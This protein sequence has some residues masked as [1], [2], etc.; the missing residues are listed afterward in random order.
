MTRTSRVVLLLTVGLLVMGSERDL[1]RLLEVPAAEAQAP[2][3]PLSCEDRL[4]ASTI[5]L[6]ATTVSQLRERGEAA[7]EI[8]ALQKRLE[9]LAAEV[10]TLKKPAE[11]K[12]E[13]K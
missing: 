10:A 3:T 8:A 13:K 2:P 11:K 5:Q 7:Q 6:H 9:Q 4:R 1:R 12:E